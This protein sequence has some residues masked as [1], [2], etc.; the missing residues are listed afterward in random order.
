[1]DAEEQKGRI[2]KIKDIKD[3]SYQQLVHGIETPGRAK[4]RA[5]LEAMMRGPAAPKL[6]QEEC[7][8]MVGQQLGCRDEEAAGRLDTLLEDKQSL[9][10]TLK[11]DASEI[12]KLSLLTGEMR[13]KFAC[14]L[15]KRAKFISRMDAYN[16]KTRS[17]HAVNE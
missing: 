5:Q 11:S 17:S 8:A 16:Y 13:M 14:Q 1:M 9:M 7:A 12:E 3:A 2:S 15:A 10:T 6:T 4:R